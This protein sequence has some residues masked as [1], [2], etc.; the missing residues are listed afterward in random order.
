MTLSISE[1]ENK[2]KTAKTGFLYLVISVFCAVVGA[3][4]E[5]Y[6]HGV[7]S[8]YML[9]AFLFPLVLG[10]VL[11][12]ALSLFGK[13]MPGTPACGFYHAGIAAW[14]VGSFMRGVLEIYGT[15]NRLLRVYP[16]T[17]MILVVIGIGIYGLKGLG[18]RN[19]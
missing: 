12:T 13:R 8:Y 18:K 10:A 17:G 9:Y 14:T 2:R 11:F 1:P 4:Y 7:Y 3:V 19:Q 16:I 6:G 5:L 15:T